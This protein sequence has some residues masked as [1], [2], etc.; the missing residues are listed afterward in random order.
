MKQGS[1][2]EDSLFV[3]L[4]WRK[5]SSWDWP[6]TAALPNL[7]KV[8]NLLLF[9]KSLQLTVMEIVHTPKSSAE[10]SEEK[11]DKFFFLRDA[12][13]GWVWKEITEHAGLPWAELPTFAEKH[14]Y[15]FCN[16]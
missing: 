15:I 8:T 3:C 7:A 13:E 12:W 6:T 2:T 9:L 10:V 1:I 11:P 5:D 14:W 16:S 4:H